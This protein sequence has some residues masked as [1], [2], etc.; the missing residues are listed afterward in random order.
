MNNPP[1]G[2]SPCAGDSATV[3]ALAN[4]R[5]IVY[6]MI[7]GKAYD[8]RRR[9]VGYEWIR[10]TDELSRSVQCSGG[11]PL[12]RHE[13]LGELVRT[14]AAQRGIC[15]PEDLI[16]DEPTRHEV[17]VDD[18]V[19]YTYCFVD[20]LML[21]FVLRDQLVEVWSTSPEGGEVTAF[22]TEEGVRGSPP[23]AVVS[24]GAV[25]SGDGPTHATLCPY[26]NAFPSRDDYERW[27]ER[28]PQA[29]TVALSIEEAFALARDWISAPV[30]DPA[31]GTCRC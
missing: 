24:F 8:A 28:T 21:P 25:R 14:M 10:V 13:T 15:R 6:P 30:G 26:L 7:S 9:P 16:S 20:A 5:K 18:R 22:V 11:M 19:L 1:A 4:I 2:A 31:G 29:A 17:R 12:R 23:G 27:A 3:G